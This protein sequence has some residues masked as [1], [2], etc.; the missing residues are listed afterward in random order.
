MSNTD[1]YHD[2]FYNFNPEQFEEIVE[3][4][5]ENSYQ[6]FIDI[7]ENSSWSRVRANKTIEEFMKK[8][9]SSK[10]K[11]DVVIYRRGYEDWRDNK[12]FPHSWCIEIGSRIDVTGG[13]LF[14]FIYV[15][16]DKLQEM[17]DKFKFIVK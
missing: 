2:I 12:W 4:T 15:K 6:Y 16:D 10:Y 7:K 11:H 13:D 1:F 5:K 14:L 3:W 8:R 9:E 17:I